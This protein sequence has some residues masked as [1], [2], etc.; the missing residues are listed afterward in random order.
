[1][2]IILTLCILNNVKGGRIQASIPK[3]MAKK[4]R[5]VIVE[6]QMYTMSNFIVIKET[7]PMKRVTLRIRILTFSHRTWVDYVANSNFPLEPFRFRTIPQLIN[8]KWFHDNELF[9]LIGEVVA[10]EDIKDLI[11]TKGKGDKM[12]GGSIARSQDLVEECVDSIKSKTSA[13]RTS[14]C[15]KA[16]T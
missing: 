4:W 3:A 11:T 10:K 5:G 14:S 6:F 1:M 7:N 13:T 16:T 8:A 15:L 2:N 12:F 9:D